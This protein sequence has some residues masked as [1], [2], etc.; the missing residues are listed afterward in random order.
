MAEIKIIGN[1]NLTKTTNRFKSVDENLVQSEILKNNFGLSNDYVEYFIYDL[2]GNL[3]NLNYNYLDYKSQSNVGLALDGTLVSLEIDPV[4]DLTSFGYS[5]GEFIGKYNFFRNR[6]SDTNAELFIKTISSDRTE[7]AVASTVLTNDEIES[8]ANELINEINSSSYFKTYLLNLGL[9]SQLLIVNVALDKRD[10]NQYLILFK[11]YEPL[12]DNIVEKTQLW[13]VDEVIESYSFDVNLDKL[14]IPD[15]PPSLKGPNFDIEIPDRN[16][17]STPYQNNNQLLN[18]YRSSNSASFYQILSFTTSQSIDINIDYT[19]YNNFSK[20]GSAEQR[21][22]NFYTKIKSIETNKNFISTYAPFISTTSSLINEI[23]KAS[24]SIENTISNFDGFEYYMYFESSSYAWPKSTSTK[25]FLLYSTGSSQVLNW[26]NNSLV[27]ASLYDDSNQEWLYYTIPSYVREDS[28]N[29]PYLDFINMIG[30][31]FDN[32]WIYLKSMTDLYKSYNNIDNGVSKDLVYYALRSLG[33]KTYN[34]KENDNLTTYIIGNN[35]GSALF[36]N[37]FTS[38]GSYLN[39]ISTQDILAETFKRIYHNVS[40]LFKSKGT[41]Y[42]LDSLN[43]IFGITSSVLEIKEFGGL[44]KDSYLKGY[45]TDKIRTSSL[46]VT[47]SVLS[48]FISLEQANTASSNFLNTDYHRVEVAFSPQNQI[49]TLISSSIATS[50]PTFKIDN[51]IGDPSYALSTSYNELQ[52]T[53]SGLFR[54][55]ITYSFDYAG[56]TRLIRYFDNTLFKTIKDYTPARANLSTGVVITSP[57]L[58]RNKIKQTSPGFDTSSLQEATYSI[59]RINESTGS[60]YSALDGDKSPYYTGQLSSSLP[61]VNYYFESTNLNP[62]LLSSQTAIL[63]TISGSA[64][65]SFNDST[66]FEHTDFNVLLN[67][68]SGSRVSLTRK[69]LEPIYA[70]T[71]GYWRTSGYVSGSNAQLQDSYET[72]KTYNLA[73]YEGVKVSSLLYNNHSTASSAYIGDTSYGRTAA[74]DKYT[75]KLG[76]FSQIVENK[77]LPNRNNVALKY[78]V[79]Q[80]GNLTELNQRNKHWEEVQRIFISG[81]TLDVSLFDNQKYGNQKIVDGTKTIF[82]SGYSYYPLVYMSI[83]ASDPRLYF[84]NLGGGNSYSSTAING[85]TP[86]TI[87]GSGTPGYPLVSG[88]IYNIFNTTVEGSSYFTASTATTFPTYSV[89]ESGDHKVEASFDMTVTMPTGETS[90]WVLGIYKNASLINSVSKTFGAPNTISASNASAYTAVY[91]Y[92]TSTLVSSTVT[93]TKNIWLGST[94]VASGT[95]FYQW[96]SVAT[97]KN[98]CSLTTFISNVYSRKA[99]SN[100]SYA[101]TQDGACG[102]SPSV[103]SYNVN[104]FW[105]IPDFA[106]AGGGTETYTF[107]L[108]SNPLNATAGDKIVLQFSTSSLNTANYTASLTAGNLTISSLSTA[109]GYS[110][111]SYPYFNS[112][113]LAANANNTSLDHVITLNSGLSNYHNRNYLFAPNPLTG[114]QNSLYSTYGDIDYAFNIKPYDIALVYLNDNTYIESRII[115]VD[116]SGSYVQLGLDSSISYTYRANLAAGTYTRFLI[117]SRVKDES[118]AHLTFRKRPGPTSYGLSISSNVHPDVLANIDTIT[119]EVKTKLIEIGGVDG[120]TL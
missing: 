100:S 113:S 107:S 104:D 20:F 18:T 43:N 55:V 11:L 96:Q 21:I 78:L 49:N 99:S 64:T 10:P 98:G 22:Y 88:K 75:Q 23:N 29:Q 1:I 68:V 91:A 37:N 73:R 58:E 27:S 85:T 74:I 94:Y 46:S 83:N 54:N 79:D 86:L 31:Y 28:S 62:Y 53:A 81:D 114:S 9:D 48:S 61:S 26:Y 57:Q 97:V 80:N 39:N 67:N 35:S 63:P 90:T 92:Y 101:G 45:N 52:S 84:E 38:T 70:L 4:N 5:S 76:L 102:V 13:I 71:G 89:Q 117:L 109:T 118:N 19:D 51:I 36:D 2:G 60:F 65:Y 15:S 50:Y 42:G 72:L 115:S 111:I 16:T 69:I 82:D 56:F 30:H 34:S 33:V 12:L 105:T 47:G 77:F 14:I 6:I 24:S 3:L 40:L 95:E 103:Y 17:I 41:Y 110:Y 32:I 119:R 25:P 116:T 112:A 7:I 106:A 66:M 59:A 87:S 108:T 44:T 120:G 8:K 93:S